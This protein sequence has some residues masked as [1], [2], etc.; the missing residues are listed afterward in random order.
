MYIIRHYSA[1]HIWSSS[2]LVS[3]GYNK[4]SLDGLEIGQFALEIVKIF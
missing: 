2:R 3:Q 1:I 4:D